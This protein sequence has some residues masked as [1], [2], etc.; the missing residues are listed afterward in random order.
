MC[1]KN[2]LLLS[3]GE[4]S[5]LVLLHQ[6]QAQLVNGRCNLV[7]VPAGMTFQP[8]NL[9]VPSHKDNLLNGE[10]GVR[11]KIKILNDI[12]DL[13]TCSTP[14]FDDVMTTDLN[15]AIDH[16]KQSC[17][18]FQES[19]FTSP[20]RTANHD[21][22]ARFYPE[23]D[24]FYDRKVCA[25]IGGPYFFELDD[26]VFATG[27]ERTSTEKSWSSGREYRSAAYFSISSS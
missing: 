18:C 1:N 5:D 16:R 8:S 20:V 21:K 12:S 2:L 19:G 17:N 4:F 27:H 25:F 22:L 24:I 23:G 14:V 13:L 6:A 9:S 3:S 15:A 26:V 11:V 7:H 10:R